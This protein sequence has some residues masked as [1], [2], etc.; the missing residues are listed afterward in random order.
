[1]PT[2]GEAIF[3]FLFFLITYAVGLCS[4]INRDV[5]LVIETCS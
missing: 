1:M 5:F 4:D 2:P 3:F